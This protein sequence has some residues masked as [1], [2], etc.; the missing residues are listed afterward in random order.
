MCKSHVPPPISH[1]PP[2]YP[3]FTPKN[4]MLEHSYINP[5][6]STKNNDQSN[7][8]FSHNSTKCVI[9]NILPKKCGDKDEKILSI[10]TDKE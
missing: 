9:L 6:K 7:F 8:L 2:S 10:I 1:V 5:P 3:I 4:L